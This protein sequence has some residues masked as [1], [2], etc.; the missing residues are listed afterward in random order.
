MSDLRVT[1][2]MGG[3]VSLGSFSGGALSRTLR[4]LSEAARVPARVDAVSG[5]S[6]GS[7]TLALAAYHLFRGSPLTQLEEDLRRAWVEDISFDGLHPADLPSHAEPSIFTDRQIRTIAQRVLDFRAWPGTPP[8][9]LFADGLVVSFALTNLNGV[10]IRAEGQ[11]IRQAE[12]GGG[13]PTG[14]DSVFADAVQTTFHDDVIRFVLRRPTPQQESAPDW[15]TGG[16]ERWISEAGH[17]AGRLQAR[18]LLPW[19]DQES[20]RGWEVFREAAIASGAFPAAFPP[21]RLGRRKEEY[22]AWPDELADG[23]FTYDYLDGG[24]LRNEPLREAIHLASEQDR[25]APRERVYIFID[26]N[27]SGTRELY[28]LAF[29]QPARL[30]QDTDAEGRVLRQTV[31]APGYLS[32]LGGV[33][34]RAGG[35]LASQAA[36]RDWIRAARVN[37]QVEWRDQAVRIIGGLQP[38]PGSDA[39][40]RIDALLREIYQEKILRSPGG[41]SSADEVTERANQA[42]QRDLQARAGGGE[43]TFSVRLLHLV[44]L[45]ANLRDKRKL[46]MVAI[47]PA[48]VPRG[49][50]TALA[51]NFLSNFGGF[52]ERNY[53]V[54]DHLKGAY[55]ADQVL[56]AAIGSATPLLVA[57]RVARVTRPAPPT[58][59]P[60]Y[61]SL[62]RPIRDR[63]ESL[64]RHHAREAAAQMGVPAVLRGMVADKIRDKVRGAVAAAAGPTAYLVVE[65][66]DA[67]GLFLRAADGGEEQKADGGHV[68]RTV[69]AIEHNPES[70]RYRVFGPNVLETGGRGLAWFELRRSGGF[71]RG[72]QRVKSLTLDGDPATWF[73]RLRVCGSPVLPVSVGTMPVDA[74]IGADQIRPDTPLGG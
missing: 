8:N 53:R 24:I 59:D 60:D 44:D 64:V 25:D 11:I 39:P 43:V 34:G 55:V 30:K 35:V 71:L 50:S 14:A 74:R 20:R 27:V 57:G 5:A 7:M 45:I 47:T 41:P 58:P 19:T 72:S 22:V 17:Q 31:E 56:H 12:A 69:I 65:F 32:R 73:D 63:F 21:V 54:H 42:L 9:P 26:P 68:I 67:A 2:I 4:L 37:S 62:P 16:R 38:G 49:E 66:A 70:Q 10:P 40:E 23:Q 61:L 13:R 18:L 46:N 52:F 29:N 28:P 3:G 15:L 51:G 6:A 48:S 33:L 1:L 36:F